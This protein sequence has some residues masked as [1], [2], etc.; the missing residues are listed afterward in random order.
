MFN[1][2]TQWLVRKGGTKLMKQVIYLAGGCFWGLEQYM[3]LA[4]GVL[5]TQ[6]GYANGKTLNPTYEEV[7]YQNTGHAETVRVEFDDEIVSLSFLLELYFDAIDPTTI[8]R[9]GG[10]TGSQYRTG[11]YYL[12]EEQKTI[13]NQ[14]IEKL[15]QKFTEKIMVEVLELSNYATAE[16]YHQKY[17]VKNPSGYCHIHASKFEQVKTRKE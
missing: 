2:V 1:V 12:N 5:D 3:S 11:I 9:Q 10:D 16:D 15:Q 13:A 17:L 7:C 8:N 4:V 6:V 14:A